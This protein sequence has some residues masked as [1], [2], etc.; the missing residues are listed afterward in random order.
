MSATSP[1]LYEPKSGLVLTVLLELLDVNET[2]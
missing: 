1:D 2:S